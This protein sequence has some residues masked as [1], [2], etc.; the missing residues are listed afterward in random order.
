MSVSTMH[1][2]PEGTGTPAG[3]GLKLRVPAE[4]T[5]GAISVHEGL[6]SPGDRI[7]LHV[8]DEADQLLYVVEGEL[9]V[10][11]GDATLL[12]RPGD[13]ISKPHGIPHGFG[14]IGTGPARVLEITAGDSFERLTLAAAR[15]SDATDFAALQAEHGVRPA[16]G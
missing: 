3:S 10:I 6:L 7:P 9:E 13:F 11:V 16:V 2:H 12:A 14:N 15:L 1:H 8:H 4:A 5:T